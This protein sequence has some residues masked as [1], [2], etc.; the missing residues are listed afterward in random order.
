MSG[1]G[2]VLILG[3]RSSGRDF[4]HAVGMIPE[5][6][7]VDGRWRSLWNGATFTPGRIHLGTVT[8]VVGIGCLQ[9]L[10]MLGMARTIPPGALQRTAIVSA[11]AFAVSGAITHWSCGRVILAY[12]EASAR[13]VEPAR[14]HRPSSR[15]ATTLLTASAGGA[16]G[17]LAVFSGCLTAAAMRRRGA[18]P[19]RWAQVTPFP[20]VM[21]TLLTFGLLPYPVGG[22]VRPASMSIGLLMFFAV[23]A[24]SAAAGSPER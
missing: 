2:D 8:G 24:A 9:W 11:T 14:G 1:I 6:V 17:A 3:R 7:E 21:S 16:L 5:H 18:G 22:Y 12:H 23:A 15:A 19:V 20:C 10:G 4:D 13:Q